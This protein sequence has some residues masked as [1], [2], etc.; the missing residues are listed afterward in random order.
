MRGKFRLAYQLGLKIE[1][2]ILTSSPKKWEDTGKYKALK[3]K[4]ITPSRKDFHTARNV[5]RLG[6]VE[7]KFK[8]TLYTVKKYSR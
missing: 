3:I 8:Y 2:P 1:L 4:C 5:D 6:I 7:L